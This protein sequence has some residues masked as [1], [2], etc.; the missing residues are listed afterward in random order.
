MKV[1][2][3]IQLVEPTTS[4]TSQVRHIHAMS[5]E[6]STLGLSK[7]GSMWR[8]VC[9]GALQLLPPLFQPRYVTIKPMEGPSFK[10]AYPCRSK[11]S[12]VYAV[13]GIDNYE[14]ETTKLLRQVVPS[15]ASFFDIGANIG[16]MTAVAKVSNPE[17]RVW[18]FEPEPKA[19][20]VLSATIAKNGWRGVVAERIALT[21]RDGTVSFFIPDGELEAS[22]NPD[23]RNG[24][25]EIQCR[26]STLDTYCC[27]NGISQIDLMKIDTESTEPDVL[28][29]GRTIIGDCKP[30]IICEVLAGRTEAQLT[31]F[32]RGLGYRFYHLTSNG[33]V[34]TELIQGD[35]TYR[36]LNYFFV[37]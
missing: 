16:L 19:Y 22:T 29:G 9:F 7:I 12:W 37:V 23:F 13:G 15:C 14:P 32:F 8:R 10:L 35:C 33:P 17:L 2:H 1:G 20:A 26:A 31:T 30:A 34:E 5:N 27:R 24:A 18:A 6:G 36:N 21:S 11:T 4:S 25:L 28:A 3:A